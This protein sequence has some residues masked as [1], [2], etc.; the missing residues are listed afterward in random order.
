MVWNTP[1][2]YVDRST[3]GIGAIQ[4]RGRPTQQLDT[5]DEHGVDRDCMILGRSGEIKSFDAI[6]QHAN[7]VSIQSP[8]DWAI[9]DGSEEGLTDARLIFQ[10]LGNRIRPGLLEFFA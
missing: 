4:K 5:L 7:T 9:G 8:N 2:D 1:I 3:D 10:G 6:A